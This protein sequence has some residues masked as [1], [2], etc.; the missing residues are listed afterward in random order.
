MST[1]LEIITVLHTDLLYV[2]QAFIFKSTN[3]NDIYIKIELSRLLL[4][5]LL[6]L[7]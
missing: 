1:I 6:L 5:L 4:L 2:R 3:I 7:L